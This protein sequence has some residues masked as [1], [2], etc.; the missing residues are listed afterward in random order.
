MTTRPTTE[1]ERTYLEL[2]PDDP[3]VERRT[4]FGGLAA[5][6]AGHMFMGLMGERL[7]FRLGESG[8]AE[9]EGRWGESAFGREGRRPMRGWVV[10]PPTL[11]T[12]AAELHNV[13]RLALE[14]AAAL[15]PKEK[16]TQTK[17]ARR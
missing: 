10:A 4:M 6:I 12:D 1:L 14:H 15:P 16:G 17:R 2:L 8:A 11:L 13:V 3:H 5:T 7:V 9:F